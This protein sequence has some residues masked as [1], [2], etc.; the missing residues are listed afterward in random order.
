[1]KGVKCFYCFREGVKL[2]DGKVGEKV[3]SRGL[4]PA[5]SAV[6][7]PF[8]ACGYDSKGKRT[9]IS[10]WLDYCPDCVEKLGENK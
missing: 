6:S 5:H 8:I 7:I 4:C 3:C 10:D 2:C 1:M 9:S